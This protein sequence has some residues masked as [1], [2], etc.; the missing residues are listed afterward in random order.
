MK[1]KIILP[2]LGL[3]LVSVV[4]LGVNQVH[5]Q[6]NGNNFYSGLVQA[7]A[8][9][10]GLDQGQVQA[11]VDQYHTQQKQNMQ[12]NMQQREQDR[13]DKLVQDGKINATQKQAIL[14]E[15]AA[16]KSKYNPANFKN[17]TADQRKQQ[18]QA[19]QDEI[20]TWAKSQGIDPS[21]LMPS[22]G[23]GGRGMFG[24]GRWVKHQPS[25]T[26]TQ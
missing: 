22:F 19:Q 20:N 15:L 11:V 16:L 12:Q 26:P 21:Y 24:A 9:K 6:S 5:A 17:M 8:Q 2:V 23:K 3:I 4:A 7:I 14:D 25:P 1:K 13:L 10:F 18:F